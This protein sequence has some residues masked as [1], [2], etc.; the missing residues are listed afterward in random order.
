MNEVRRPDRTGPDR[1]DARNG[2]YDRDFVTRPGRLRMRVAR[3][4]QRLCWLAGLSRSERCGAVDHAPMKAD[5]QAIYQATSWREAIALAQAF[6]RLWREAYPQLMTRLLLNL[7]GLLAF[8]Q[9]P[10]GLWRKLRT[11]NVIERCFVEV[12]RRTRPI[13][14][15]V[16]VQRVERII[17]PI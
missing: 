12:R 8:S 1:T 9:D 10:T 7:P 3:T 17:F 11:T 6:A 2:F 16:N 13:V 14:R 5:A 15:F 4:R